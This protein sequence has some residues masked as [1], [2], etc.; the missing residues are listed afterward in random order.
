MSFF[1]EDL[2]RIT[3]GHT[4]LDSNS[5][6]LTFFYR[7]CSEKSLLHSQG[8]RR[9]LQQSRKTWSTSTCGPPI[10]TLPARSRSLVDVPANDASL[11]LFCPPFSIAYGLQIFWQWASVMAEQFPAERAEYRQST[12]KQKELNIVSQKGS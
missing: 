7:H 8:W 11:D 6:P 1:S 2:I 12:G 9:F 3:L 5:R 4:E 10:P